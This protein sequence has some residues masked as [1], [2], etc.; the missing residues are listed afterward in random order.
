MQQHGGGNGPLHD[1]LTSG[2][3]GRQLA[4]TVG[5]AALI[6]F[7]PFPANAFILTCYFFYAS[8]G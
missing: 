8:E 1:V 3:K 5:L 7:S 2:L 6:Y 4:W